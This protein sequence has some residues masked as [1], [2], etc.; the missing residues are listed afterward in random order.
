MAPSTVT[1]HVP[2]PHIF[3][4][5]HLLAPQT[6]PRHGVFWGNTEREFNEFAGYYHLPSL[7]VKSAAYQVW[8]WWGVSDMQSGLLVQSKN[9][10]Q[11]IKERLPCLHTC[12]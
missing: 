3:A 1:P 7:S 8:K 11:F 6:T 5:D 9:G 4:L 12:L 2:F 10:D